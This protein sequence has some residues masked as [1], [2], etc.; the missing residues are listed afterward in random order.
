LQ[1]YGRFLK[2]ESPDVNTQGLCWFE[3]P[4]MLYLMG[5]TQD[6]ADFLRCNKLHWSQAEGTVHA[7]CAKNGIFGELPVAFV[8]EKDMLVFCRMLW[9][10]VGDEEGAITAEQALAELPPPEVSR[11]SFIHK[12]ASTPSQIECCC[13]FG[14]L[15]EYGST[16]KVRQ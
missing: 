4:V 8:N 9:V 5:R 15:D 12:R 2:Q 1:Y 3:W 10:L 13:S 14:S 6:A 7:L 11:Y 16:K